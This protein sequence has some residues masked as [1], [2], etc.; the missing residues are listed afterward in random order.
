MIAGIWIGFKL[1]GAVDDETFRKAVLV[2]F[3]LRACR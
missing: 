1:Y 3:S 2:W